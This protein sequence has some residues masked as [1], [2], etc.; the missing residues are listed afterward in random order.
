[1]K[2]IL[3][4]VIFLLLSCTEQKFS[5]SKTTESYTTALSE[6]DKAYN[7]DNF[8]LAIEKYTT[9]LEID[10]LNAEAFYKRAFSSAKLDDF[11]SAARDYHRAAELGYR[12]ADCYHN[13]GLTY[14]IAFQDYEKAHYYLKKGYELNPTTNNRELMELAEEELLKAQKKS[15]S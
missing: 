9:V 4:A 6:A 2:Y 8:K 13:L 7:S 14:M 10:S 15:D 12:I 1:M 3:P 11:E 5:D